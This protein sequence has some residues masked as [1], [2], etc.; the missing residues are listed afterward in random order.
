MSPEE[1]AARH[2]QD[3]ASFSFDDFEYADPVLDRWIQ[4]LGKT[5]TTPG[6][7]GRCQEQF[8]SPEELRQ[9]RARA[10]EPF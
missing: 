9:V 3:W 4:H 5:F 2:G 6:A 10:E 8:L 1:Y 7:I